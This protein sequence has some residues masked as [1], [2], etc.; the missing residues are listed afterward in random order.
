MDSLTILRIVLPKKVKLYT[1]SPVCGIQLYQCNQMK[2]GLD[3]VF[4]FV[5]NSFL[6][7]EFPLAQLK[8][9]IE[10]P[11]PKQSS[12]DQWHEEP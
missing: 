6:N 8:H 9:F 4:K 2:T 10:P 1:F 3:A 5:V 11:W 12:L 7:L